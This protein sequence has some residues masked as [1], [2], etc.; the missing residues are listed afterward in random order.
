[1]SAKNKIRGN[2]LEKEVVQEAAFYRLYARR[3]PCSK[4]SFLGGQYHD[5]VDV[6]L[7]EKYTIQCKRVKSLLKGMFDFLPTTHK[8]DIVAFR[9]DSRPKKIYATVEIVFLFDL[10]SRALDNSS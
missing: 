8:T 5:Q 7:E 2:T 10:L 6:L 3:A 4:G 1:M 9:Q